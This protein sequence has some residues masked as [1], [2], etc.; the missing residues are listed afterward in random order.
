MVNSLRNIFLLVLAVLALPLI[1]LLIPIGFVL[2]KFDTEYLKTVAIGIDQYGG[3]VLY[4]QENFTV[5][6]YTYLLCRKKNNKLACYFMKFIDLLFGKDHCMKSFNW[7]IEND[8]SFFS[9]V[10]KVKGL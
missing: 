9:Y 6:S 4:N 3:S 10:E 8:L 2:R 5:S 1:T 7:E